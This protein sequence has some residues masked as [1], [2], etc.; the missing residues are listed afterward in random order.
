METSYPIASGLLDDLWEVTLVLSPALRVVQAYGPVYKFFGCEC[1]TLQGRDIHSLF[2][3]ESSKVL[4]KHMTP[5]RARA[6]KAANL[7]SSSSLDVQPLLLK[8]LEVS[9]DF[10]THVV[11]VSIRPYRN[12]NTGVAGAYNYFVCLNEISHL[13]DL[14][15]RQNA[16]LGMVNHEL[17]TPLNGIIGLSESLRLE[18]RDASKRGRFDMLLNSA[19]CMLKLVNTVIGVAD[20][21]S[22]AADLDLTL[23]SVNDLVE[24]LCEVLTDTVD[25][26]GSKLK[27]D[28]VTLTYDLTDDLPPIYLD[29]Q[30][31]Y[32]ALEAIVGNGLKF[33]ESGSVVIST[34]MDFTTGGIVVTVSDTG[35]GISPEYLVR[36]FDCFVQEDERLDMRQF[37]GLGLGLTLAKEICS[38]HGGQ[39]WAESELG[40]GSKFSMLLPANV[41][42]LKVISMRQRNLLPTFTSNISARTNDYEHESRAESNSNSLRA[43]SQISSIERDKQSDSHSLAS[44]SKIGSPPDKSPTVSSIDNIGEFAFLNR[45]RCYEPLVELAVCATDSATGLRG[46]NFDYSR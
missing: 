9:S 35:L 29:K 46:L 31:I 19:Q 28:S 2:T 20:L 45:V 43:S 27:K 18:E 12:S 10:G 1:T 6:Q 7:N 3:H 37:E 32:Q 11:S 34:Q 8:Q 44:N 5:L 14:E 24:E 33:T 25:K 38:L 30:K 36:I 4:T 23:V 22:N 13:Q 21:Q 41:R 39:L 15:K 17:R 26:R 42:A 40:R 16:F